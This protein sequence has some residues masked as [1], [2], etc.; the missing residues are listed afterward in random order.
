MIRCT[1]FST[2]ALILFVCTALTFSACKKDDP[3]E[4][5]NK[6]LVIDNGARSIEPGESL[7][8][9]ASFVDEQG[10]VSAAS[11]VQWSSENT[12]VVSISASGVVSAAGFGTTTITATVQEDGTTHPGSR[13]ACKS[14]RRMVASTR[15]GTVHSTCTDAPI[16]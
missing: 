5:L 9:T 2:I 12:S 3:S 8:Y 16:H 7:T 11:S 14:A 13:L 15:K 1:N 4:D 6:V 10:N